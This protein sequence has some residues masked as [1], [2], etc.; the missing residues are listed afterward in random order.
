[1][2]KRQ[3]SFMRQE[4]V[5]AEFERSLVKVKKKVLVG[6]WNAN[7]SANGKAAAQATYTMPSIRREESKD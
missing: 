1:M 4:L 6:D 3:T 2:K 5:T 7:K